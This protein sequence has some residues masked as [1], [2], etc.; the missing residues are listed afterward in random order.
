MDSKQKEALLLQEGGDLTNIDGVFYY[1]PP[2]PPQPPRPEAIAITKE[3]IQAI[4]NEENSLIVGNNNAIA[5]ANEQ[6]TRLQEDN[7]VRSGRIVILTNY[8]TSLNGDTI[9]GGDVITNP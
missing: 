6:I 4:I 1:H 5:R 9:D 3:D 2:Q 7:T 8:I